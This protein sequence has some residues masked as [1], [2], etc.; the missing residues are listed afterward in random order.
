MPRSTLSH[1]GKGGSR[2]GAK[3]G[4]ENIGK[5]RLIDVYDRYFES[6]PA[7]TEVGREAAYRLRYEVYCV[8]HPF[9]DPA[10]NTD[11]LE[12]DGFDQY[13]LHS[14][15]IH[16]PSDTVAGA[17]RLI[18]PQSDQN[19][20]DL[21]IRAICRQPLLHQD[22]DDL[23]RARTAEI[24]RFAVSKKFRRRAG[25]DETTVGSVN[26]GSDP[27]RMIPHISLGLMRSVVAMTREAGMT[28]LCAVMEPSLLRLLKKLGI[29]I[30]DLGPRID[31]HGHRQPCF[32]HL[33]ALLART[34]VEQREV[35]QILTNDG[36]LWPLNED[37]I[38]PPA[39]TKP[40]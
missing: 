13:S 22:S 8:E 11:G 31:Y 25:D 40:N 10:N 33:D 6:V 12:R 24:S 29:H 18:L 35:W 9:E 16:R 17:V 14:L 4:E 21:P 34:W 19:S 23:P 5:E 36:A 39:S 32:A 20:A 2:R 26:D 15:L 3:R 38:G 30:N 7:D 28:H 1:A 27:R 37:Y